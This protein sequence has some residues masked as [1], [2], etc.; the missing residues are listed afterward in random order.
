M[1]TAIA[2]LLLVQIV[3]S[4]IV[5]GDFG[6]FTYVALILVLW[7]LNIILALVVL[8]LGAALGLLIIL[9]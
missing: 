6:F 9:D 7:S 8:F 4:L 5:R 3:S 2:L 1:L